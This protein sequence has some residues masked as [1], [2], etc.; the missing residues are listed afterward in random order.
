MEHSKRKF[1]KF[2]GKG[3][4][5]LGSGMIG[6]PLGACSRDPI[7]EDLRDLG[8]DL[9]DDA[10]VEEMS[11]PE[12]EEFV[13]QVDD[14]AEAYDAEGRQDTISPEDSIEDAVEVGDVKPRIPPGQHL[15]ETQPV[16]GSNS[17]PRSVESWKFYVKGEVEQDLEFTWEEFNDLDQ[18]EQIS[19]FHCVTSWTMLDIPWG[20][21]R[22][23]TLLAMAGLTDKAK[24]VI[25]DCEHGYT[26][27]M[28][29][30]EVLKDN[31]LIAMRRFGGDLPDKYGGPARGLVPDRYGYKSGKWVIGLRVVEVDE[32]GFWETKGY[33]NTALPWEEDRYS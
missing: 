27:N 31:V 2:M 26:T 32:P 24:H 4:V 18:V 20:G 33:S 10:Q 22:V 21:V 23:S 16:L 6:I 29:L 14:A 8:P 25:F 7:Y 3:F 17:D 28:D 11:E 19:D 15:V 12:I 5:V 13:A 30:A 1:L 9:L